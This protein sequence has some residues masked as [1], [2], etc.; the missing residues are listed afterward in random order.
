[1]KSSNNSDNFWQSSFIILEDK[2]L[3]QSPKI[4]DYTKYLI[5]DT[6]YKDININQINLLEKIKLSFLKDF[7]EFDELI[8]KRQNKIL[9]SLTSFLQSFVF[10]PEVIDFIRNKTFQ[11][12]N[13]YLF[14]Y[15]SNIKYI[16]FTISDLKITPTN[17]NL[18]S[19]L[20]YFYSMKLFRDYAIIILDDDIG[21]LDDTFESLFNAYIENPNII[22]GKRTHL[23]TQSNNGYYKGYFNWIFQQ[24]FVKEAN[25]SLILTNLGSTIFPPNILKINEK[26]LLIINETITCDDLILK[27]LSN[28]KGIPPKLVVNNNF[29]GIKRILPKTNDK[30]LYRNNYNSI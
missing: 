11:I 9:V 22:S 4:F 8:K 17:K 30:P 3:L 19:H 2:T 18:R 7:P 13:I 29:L 26:L 23:M 1:L 16:N 5:N 6:N 14:L 24:N 25:F 12:N 20:K 21:Y 10:I 27:Y 28:I 15:K